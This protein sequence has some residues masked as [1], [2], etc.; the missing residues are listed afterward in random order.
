MR[1]EQSQCEGVLKPLHTL[2]CERIP[3]TRVLDQPIKIIVMV[4]SYGII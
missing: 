4:A 1:W 2:N 3:S